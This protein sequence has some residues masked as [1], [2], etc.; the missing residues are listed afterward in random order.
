MI[1]FNNTNELNKLKE[2]NDT[3]E[4]RINELENSINISNNTTVEE[5]YAEILMKMQNSH[6]KLN[7]D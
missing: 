3:L 2:K 5:N 1:F 7:K 4:K 6:L